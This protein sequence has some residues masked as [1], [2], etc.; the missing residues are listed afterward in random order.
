MLFFSD[1]ASPDIIFLLPE[2]PST[3]LIVQ[4]GWRLKLLFCLFENVFIEFYFW[5]IFSL[6]IDLQVNN[7]FFLQNFKDIR[8]LLG[9]IVSNEKSA[10]SQRVGI[11]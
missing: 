11:L 10:I 4:D 5:S 3:F 2:L 7:I 1:Q 6:A 8:C 9:A